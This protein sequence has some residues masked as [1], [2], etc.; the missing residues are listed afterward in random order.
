MRRALVVLCAM[1]LIA[2][3]AAGCATSNAIGDARAQLQNAKAAGAEY[4]APN[5]YF[6]A[7]AYLGQA[8]YQA[9]KGDNKQA[10]IFTKQSS[11]YSAKALGMAK[12]GAK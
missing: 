9:G 12:G 10:D 4:S 6:A 8:V 5:E 7:E 3:L 2:G 11:D 1:F